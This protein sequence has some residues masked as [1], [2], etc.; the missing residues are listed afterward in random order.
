MSLFS[1]AAIVLGIIGAFK[2]LGTA[3]VWLGARFDISES[4]L[5]Y[6]AFAVVFIAI[7]IGVI[8]LGKIIKITIDKTFLGWFDQT[9]GSLL[10][11]L[12]AAFLISVCLWILQLLDLDLPSTWTEGAWL[13]PYVEGFAPM[14]AVWLSDYV[15][16]FR[17]AF[18]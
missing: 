18:A 16:F 17:D 5:P 9:A 12:K 3:M 14:V 6:V 10:G 4:V 7:L 11:V 15:S 13:F 1:L 8:L 2:L